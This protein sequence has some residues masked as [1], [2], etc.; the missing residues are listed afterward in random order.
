MSDVAVN[1]VKK[2]KEESYSYMRDVME[3]FAHHKAALISMF[4]LGLIILLCIFLPFIMN[5]DPY[6]TDSLSVYAAPSA[7]HILGTDEIGRDLFARLV[8]GGRTSLMVG[9]VSMLISVFIGVPLGIL[10]GYY[11]GW[12]EALVLRLADVF[13]SFPSIVLSMVM[14]SIMGP[15]L[16]SVTIVIGITGWPQ[17]AR[18]IY[19][20]V[21]ITREMEYV[22]SAKATGIKDGRIMTQYILPNALS[23]VLINMTFRT[24]Q[25]ILMEAS[26]SFLGLGVK[27]P[28]A[29]WGNILQYAQ[30]IS[31]L[32]MR[33]WMWMPAGILMLITVV[34]VNFIGDG[35]RDALDPKLKIQ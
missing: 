18:I 20:K 26:L 29:S 16:T 1:A 21:I 23:P 8:Y 5:L 22:Q 25:A 12:I 32:M 34:T 6:S 28:T 19:S 10:A 24:A 27:P 33:P 2:E 3:R 30:N 35:I 17:F 13:M 11:R 15:S 7:E 14:V 4:I 31:S 9:V